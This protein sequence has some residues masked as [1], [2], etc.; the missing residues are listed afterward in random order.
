MNKIKTIIPKL[1]LINNIR[2][3]PSST[4]EHTLAIVDSGTNV[5]LTKKPQ[6]Q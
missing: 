5:N 3:Q 6:Q 4:S 2:T 1:S